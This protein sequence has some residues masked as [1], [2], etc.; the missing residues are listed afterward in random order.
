MSNTAL[1]VIDVQKEYFA[2]HGKLVLPDGPKALE[3]IQ[4]LLT[5]ARARQFP[6]IHILHQTTRPNHP[7]FVKGTVGAELHDEIVPAVN[8]PIIF[9]HKPGS[10]TGT[11]LA[12]IL[13]AQSVDRL[14]ICGYMTH[15]CCDTTTREAAGMDYQVI[16]AADATATLDLGLGEQCIPHHQVH[17]T[18]L[19]IMSFFATVQNTEEIVK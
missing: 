14:V 1:L 17:Q 18:T 19:A 11:R 9:K 8:E 4:T 7:F 5:W 2:P 12:E 15:M 13:Q 10:F 16:F 6:V 3:N